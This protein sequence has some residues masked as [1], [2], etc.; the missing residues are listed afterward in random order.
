MR[1]D[2]CVKTVACDHSSDKCMAELF[3]HT[4]GVVKELRLGVG[5]F[6]CTSRVCSPWLCDAEGFV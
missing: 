6:V 4:G 3:Q 1:I 2:S 5:V